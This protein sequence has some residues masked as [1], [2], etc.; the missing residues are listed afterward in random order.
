MSV[1]GRGR[2]STSAQLTDA[3]DG[4]GGGDRGR[5]SGGEGNDAGGSEEEVGP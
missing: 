5:V 3:S 4:G 2:E 1:P